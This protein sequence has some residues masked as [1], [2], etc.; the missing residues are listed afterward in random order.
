[1][2][3]RYGARAGPWREI[4]LGSGYWSCDDTT[5]VLGRDGEPTGLETR[6]PGLP[7]HVGPLAAGQMEIRVVRPPR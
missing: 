1:V 6:W 4:R 3:L 5:A 7:T 2:R